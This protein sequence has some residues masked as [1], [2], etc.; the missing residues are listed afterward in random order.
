MDALTDVLRA[1]RLSG[2]VFLDAEFTEPWCIISKVGPEDCR[3]FMAEPAQ[4]IAYHYVV[5]GRLLMRIAGQAPISA[6]A[7]HLLVLPRN[8]QHLLGSALDLQPTNADELIEP[9]GADGLARIRFGGGGARTCILCGFLGSSERSAPLIAS[10]PAVVQLDLQDNLTG[11]WIESSIRYAARELSAGGPGTSANLARLAEILFTAAIHEY[12]KALP[13]GQKGWLAGLRD[14]CVGRT[15]AL[16]HGQLTHPWTLDALAHEVG[17]SRST[18]TERFTRHI[19][20]PPMRYLSR[21]RLL[22][23][24]ERLRDGQQS[25][26]EIGYEVGYESEAAFNR[27][28]KREFGTAPGAFRKESLES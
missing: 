23:A 28:F 14:P 24:A 4:L 19:G 17:L 6:T 3:P 7:G 9:A 10:L 1:M 21:R 26:A 13:P 8:D 27:A 22:L 20:A 11:T 15:L 18:L 2:G 16:I 5:E 25:V 12:V